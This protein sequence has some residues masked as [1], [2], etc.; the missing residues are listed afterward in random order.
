MTV[1]A[2]ARFSDG[3]TAIRRDTYDG[4]VWTASPH[5]VVHDTG[6]ELALA[7]WPGIR[8]LAPTTWIDWL[9]TGDTASRDASTTNLAARQWELGP[10]TWRDTIWLSIVGRHAFFSVN[11][12]FTQ[13]HRLDRWY[14][15]FQ[16]PYRRTLNGID[17]F[18][19]FVD[20]VVEPDLSRWTWKDEDE[21][22]QG[23]RM[24]IITDAEHQGVQEARAEVVAM[25]ENRSG[26][27]G[28]DWPHWRA[29]P[30]WP[31]PVLPADVMTVE[32]ASEVVTID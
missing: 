1:P 16:R 23:R 8:S 19:L 25:I 22:D 21:Y 2:A 4:R 5:R 17:T 7:Y 13:D 20:L 28:D 30:S 15:N 10:W 12:F 29:A 31:V 26:V 32:V 27:F 9:R 18:D 3:A 24:G 6:H 14:I 11:L